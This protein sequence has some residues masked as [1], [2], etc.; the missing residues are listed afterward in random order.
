MAQ[1]PST[2]KDTAPTT[3]Y[4]IWIGGDLARA[5]EIVRQFCF[6][7]GDCYAVAPVE[8]VYT[9]GQE[10]GVC[11]TRINYPRF[12]ASRSDIESRVQDLAEE[13]RAGLCQQS[14][15]IEGPAHTT[16][17]SNRSEGQA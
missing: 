13:L 5:Q 12:P 15:S 4:R 7:R 10:S 3:T 14:Y 2:R 6:A 11:V 16:W 9:G 17:V 8:Y 1:P